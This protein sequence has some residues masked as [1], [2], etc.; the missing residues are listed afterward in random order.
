MADTNVRTDEA[1]E[2][3]EA[4]ASEA[5]A[6]R[7]PVPAPPRPAPGAPRPF[8]FPRFERRQ[9]TNGLRLVVAPVSKLPV[10]TVVAVVEAGAAE[11]PPGREGLAQLTARALV[12]GTTALEGEALTDRLERLGTALDASADWDAAVARMTVLSSRLA[13]AF[14]LMGSVLMAPAFPEREVERLKAERLADLLQLRAEPRGLADEMF[15]RFAYA[16]TARYGRPE[17]GSERSVQTITRDDVARFY[18]ARY[19]PAGTTLIVAG[20][21]SAD[22]IERLAQDT[23]GGWAGAEPQAVRASDE[24]ASPGRRVHVVAKEDAPQSELRIGHVGLPRTHP[25]FFPV[26][27]MNA[28]LGGLFSSRINL[29]LREAHAYTYG[30]HSEFDWR[31]GAGPFVVST[32]VKSDVTD[33]AARETLAEVDRMRA[34][35]VA[36]DELSLATSY[37]DGVFPI[38]Y[39]TTAAVATALANLVIY[40]LPDDYFDT[41]RT[42]VRAV[43]AAA[44]HEAARRHLHPDQLQIVVVGDPAVVREPLEALDFGPVMVHDPEESELR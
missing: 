26:V 2:R 32:A 8:T 34:E 33:A 23:L 25:D 24:P 11:D 13:E 15:S 18:A 14:A 22:L 12:E 28:I 17:G 31:R 10:V 37:L 30:A 16:T 44:V 43:S 1:R 21:V 7:A 3:H 6:S 4:G 19:R 27:V 39:E 9:L 36:A 20:D 29:N 35:P 40:G 42:N 38:R 5:A 41:Y